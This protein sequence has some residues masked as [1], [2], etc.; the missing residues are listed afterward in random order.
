M[1]SRRRKRV[2]RLSL[3]CSCGA[4][5]LIDRSVVHGAWRI[6][7]CR[8]GLLS[9]LFILLHRARRAMA[10]CQ[11][12]ISVALTNQPFP[13]SSTKRVYLAKHCLGWC[14][15]PNWLLVKKAV[16]TAV[17]ST[18]RL[19]MVGGEHGIRHRFK[20]TQLNIERLGTSHT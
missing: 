15:Q 5:V 10:C 16:A 13:V 2:P 14:V 3:S 7:P 4:W 20:N 9:V 11:S 1:A 17:L 18:W 12:S 6:F 19:W 8:P